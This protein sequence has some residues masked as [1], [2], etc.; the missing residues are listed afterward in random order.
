[1][2]GD[3]GAEYI[4]RALNENHALVS[5]DLS[6]NMFSPGGIARI[7][8]GCEE[9]AFLESLSVSSQ[10]DCLNF[11]ALAKNLNDLL[12]SA[13]SSLKVL[14][15][16]RVRIDEKSLSDFVA[17]LAG[18][19]RVLR[20]DEIVFEG[21]IDER[22]ESTLFSALL[23]FVYTKPSRC[24]QTL[25]L[26]S[27]LLKREVIEQLKQQYAQLCYAR[28]QES[29]EQE[30][31]DPRSHAEARARGRN[32]RFLRGKG[33]VSGK[34]LG[35]RARAQSWEQDAVIGLTSLD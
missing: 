23:D 3:E 24:L 13:Y 35:R 30:A 26:F 15:L 12:M 7:L 34:D 5:L 33:S 14:H 11:A 21:L 16:G 31:S 1:M 8:K 2:I 22:I 17:L 25:S 19:T 9:N 32:V 29:K 4:A 18:F 28:L 6:D 20:I 10:T 27:N